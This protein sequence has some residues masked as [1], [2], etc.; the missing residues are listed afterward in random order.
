MSEKHHIMFV[1]NW[2]GEKTEKKTASLA[3]SDAAL[4]RR[5]QR[6]E[7]LLGGELKELSLN[8]SDLR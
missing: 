5:V 2:E 3:E 6:W 1:C 4:L 8:F 7:K